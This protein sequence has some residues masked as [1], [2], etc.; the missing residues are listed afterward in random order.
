MSSTLGMSLV[1]AI[2]LALVHAFSGS[3]HRGAVE[4]PRWMAAASGLSLA[5]VFVHVLPE[6]AEV[7]ARWLEDRPQRSLT[8]FENQI[9]I[10]A[11][12]GVLLALLFGRGSATARGRS[13][14]G[15][16]IGAFAV[17]NMLIGG[18]TLRLGSVVSLMV[19]ALAFGTHL[20]V[21]DHALDVEYGLAYR[22]VGRW[23]LSAATVLGW[24]IAAFWPPPM[25]VGASLLSLLSGA[26][27]LN[28]LRD[29]LT[30]KRTA[31]PLAFIAGTLGYTV[32]LLALDYSQYA[33]RTR[34][35]TALARPP[36]TARS[37]ERI[38]A[39]GSGGR[40]RGRRPMA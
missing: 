3:L 24:L 14:I 30:P 11:L 34:H 8:W 22:R 5:Y 6:L 38:G 10:M 15:L 1:A 7:Q 33:A 40:V 19:A 26:V 35:E 13:R 36:V 16:R 31:H 37:P 4:R 39:R 2:F 17:Y 18:L 27:I 29:E 28:V 9:Y 23:V 12:I 21:N 32:L 20:L 25:M